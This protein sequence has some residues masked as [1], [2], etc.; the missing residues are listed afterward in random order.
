MISEITSTLKDPH[1][2]YPTGNLIFGG[3]YNT[4]INEWLDRSPSKHQGH[5]LNTVLLEFCSAFN[6]K[7]MWRTGNPGTRT[8]TWFQPDGSVKSRTDF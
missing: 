4:V 5:F 6:L 3:D 2:R 1:Q 8:N 7:D